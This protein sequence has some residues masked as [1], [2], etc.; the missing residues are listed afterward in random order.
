MVGVVRVAGI[1]PSIIRFKIPGVLGV[2]GDSDIV[3]VN[4]D[5]GVTMMTAVV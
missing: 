2:V 5:V 3:C 1:V 4:P